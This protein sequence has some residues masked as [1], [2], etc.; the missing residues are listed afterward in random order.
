MPVVGVE[1]VLV[2]AAVEKGMQLISIPC[3]GLEIL[4]CSLL[5]HQ[6]SVCAVLAVRF[7]VV[8]IGYLDSSPLVGLATCV[9]YNTLG[10]VSSIYVW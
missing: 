4:L 6:V 8:W 5:G 1:V 3:S 2:C 10:S 7:G 9:P